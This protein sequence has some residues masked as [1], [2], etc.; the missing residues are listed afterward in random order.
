[1]LNKYKVVNISSK[2]ATERLQNG[3]EWLLAVLIVTV[4]QFVFYLL[5]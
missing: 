5:G 2:I 3:S 4:I 1:M